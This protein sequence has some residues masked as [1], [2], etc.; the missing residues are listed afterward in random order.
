MASLAALVGYEKFLN[1]AKSASEVLAYALCFAAEC[2]FAQL[3]SFAQLVVHAAEL[4][5]QPRRHG[6]VGL[7][8]EAQFTKCLREA[9]AEAGA[10]GLD[11][12]LVQQLAGA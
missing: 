9:V 12:R 2:T 3:Q 8:T 6:H 7:I 4:M 10:N 5:Q 11:A 1:A